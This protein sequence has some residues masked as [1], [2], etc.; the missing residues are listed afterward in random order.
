MAEGLPERGW[1]HQLVYL[2]LAGTIVFFGLL[3]LAR[4]PGSLPGPDLLMC[5]TLAWAMRR[6][7]YLPALLVGV[8]ILVEDFLTM[9]PPGL[10]AAIVVIAC[11]FLRGRSMLTRELPFFVEWLL[12]SGVM[13]AM[14]LAYRLATG[15]AFVPQPAFG[16]ALAQT[17]WSI[18]AYPLV[19]GASRAVFG[20]HKPAMGE[21]DDRG[22]KL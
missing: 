14:L 4:E 20:L 1:V 6:P 16:I 13:V 19:V 18:L 3:P 8:V 9:R 2:A 11:E 17:L 5:L 15:I 7:D 22:R 21:V 10:W 12:I